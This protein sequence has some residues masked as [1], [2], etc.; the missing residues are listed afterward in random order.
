MATSSSTTAGDSRGRQTAIHHALM[1]EEKK[2]LK[3]RILDLILEAYDLPTDSASSPALA[4]SS[5]IQV[6][7]T[8]LRLFQP[9]DFDDLIR[10]R[11][12]DDR[13]GYALCP[14]PNK[15]IPGGGNK[16][17]NRKGGQDFRIVDRAELENWCSKECSERGAFVRAQLSDEAAWLREDQ[18]ENIK[19]LDEMR[20]T[21]DLAEAL[22]VRFLQLPHH[23]RYCSLQGDCSDVC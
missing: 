20:K 11:N 13:C 10:E 4:T 14:K 16:V 17:W 1:L 23:L 22:Q 3:S 19:L 18:N 6:F 15:K 9:S 5:D 7:K 2:K 8:G 21:D 12:I